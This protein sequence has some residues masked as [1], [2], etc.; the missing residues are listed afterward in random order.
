MLASVSVSQLCQ[1]NKHC[2]SLSGFKTMKIYSYVHTHSGFAR[3]SGTLCGPHDETSRML[4]VIKAERKE[5]VANH[6]GNI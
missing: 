2:H 6:T 5:K 4:P 1:Y 3:V